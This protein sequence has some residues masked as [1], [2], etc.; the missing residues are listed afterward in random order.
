MST[1][2]TGDNNNDFFLMEAVMLHFL[3]EQDF[4]LRYFSCI[5]ALNELTQCGVEGRSLDRPVRDVFT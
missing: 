5:K 3:S 2:V 4:E 1:L